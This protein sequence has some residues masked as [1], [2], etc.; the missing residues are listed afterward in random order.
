M[1]R[2]SA[3]ESH[4]AESALA[5][6][7]AH[8]PL[9]SALSE[10][11]EGALLPALLHDALLGPLREFAARPRKQLRSRLLELL[12]R[13]AG[14]EPGRLA[15]ALP[16]LIEALH[17]GSL[18]ID[19]I[20][21][22][23]LSRRGAPAL[24]AMHGMPRALNAGNYLYFFAQAQL[25]RV[26]LPDRDRLLAFERVTECLVRCHQGQALDLHVRA[27]ALAQH[28][29]PAVVQAVSAWKTGSL[30]ALAAELAALCAGAPEDVRAAFARFGREVGI[31]LQMFDDLSGVL[32]PRR[33][34]KGIEDLQLGRPTWV[35]AFL[36]LDLPAERYAECQRELALVIDGGDPD[37]LLE[38]LRFRCAAA[39]RSRARR[40]L[41]DA[42]AALRA[43]IGDGPRLLLLAQQLDEL[44]AAYVGG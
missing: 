3:V 15:P 13:V 27:P 31:G 40:Q 25:M 42:L 10:A 18:I 22:G 41:D 14:G 9:G 4:A 2:R 26:C 17:E 1:T 7:L 8:A 44:E 43:A 30:L 39:G 16:L 33:R 5:S 12:Y 34:G 29:L 19:D 37:G 32:N 23:S 21:D 28:E 20:E 38:M 35:L 6:A 36:A 24:H 11:T